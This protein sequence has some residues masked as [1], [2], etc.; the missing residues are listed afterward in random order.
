VKY[1]RNEKALKKLGERIRDLRVSQNTSQ[2]QLA[3]E[4]GIP[5]NQ[6]GRIERGEINVGVSTLFAIAKTLNLEVKE[7]FDFE[8]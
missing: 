7:I 2:G 5:L 8:I 4:A 1:L 6:V 3:F